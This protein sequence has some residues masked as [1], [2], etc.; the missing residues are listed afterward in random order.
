[1][2]FRM[3]VHLGEVQ[4]QGERLFGTGI[5]IAARLEGLAEPGGICISSKVYEEVRGKLDLEFED[6]GEH[7]VKNIPEPVRVFSVQLDERPA[8]SLPRSS[9]A[10]PIFAAAGP[11]SSIAPRK[12]TAGSGSYPWP[13]T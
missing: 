3:G 13:T 2:Q 5:N 6:L 7:K 4:T 11:P 9:R 1:M 10:T 12:T 8:Q